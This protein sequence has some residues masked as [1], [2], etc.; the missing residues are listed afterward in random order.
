M[1]TETIRQQVSNFPFKLRDNLLLDENGKCPDCIAVLD[2][3]G[4]YGCVYKQNDKKSFMVV[5]DKKEVETMYD[6]Y[7]QLGYSTYFE[8]DLDE[9]KVERVRAARG[10]DY[11]EEEFWSEVCTP[12]RHKLLKSLLMEKGINFQASRLEAPPRQADVD[13]LLKV[14]NLKL[15]WYSKFQDRKEEEA[16]ALKNE[17][18]AILGVSKLRL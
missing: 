15:Q 13:K 3:G 1:D 11:T 17:L 5:V 14:W 2:V 9:K 4:Y 7:D 12:F 16:Y 10:L 18:K 6:I 8:W